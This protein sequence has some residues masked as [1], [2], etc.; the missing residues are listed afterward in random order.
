MILFCI[1]VASY[2][3]W[4][5]SSPSNFIT[6]IE[7]KPEMKSQD[8]KW[9]IYISSAWSLFSWQEGI[10]LQLIVVDPTTDFELPVT[11]MQGGVGPIIIWAYLIYTVHLLYSTNFPQLYPYSSW[12][13]QHYK[14]GTNIWDYNRMSECSWESDRHPWTLPIHISGCP[15]V[16]LS[17]EVLVVLKMSPLVPWLH[18]CSPKWL[19]FMDVSGLS[20][21]SPA[22]G[23]LGT[24]P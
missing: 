2:H 4:N 24:L 19:K 5:S 15:L 17:F 8:L 12:V 18:S 1:M 21:M 16:M 11:L 3:M 23:N 10:S 6:N 7:T 9:Y 13:L 14:A 22:S 20:Q